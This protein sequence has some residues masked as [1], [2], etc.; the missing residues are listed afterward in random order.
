MP[1]IKN[2][3]AAQR[4][5]EIKE[6]ILRTDKE[7]QSIKGGKLSQLVAFRLGTEEYALKIEEIKEVVLT[8]P[9]THVP[10]VPS[11]IKGVANIRGNLLA[12]FDLEER[13]GIEKTGEGT[14]RYTLVL[15][16][17]KNKIGILVQDVP[18]TIS[19][20]EDD[21]D[22]SNPFLQEAAIDDQAIHSLAK[23]GN[24]LIILLNIQNVLGRDEILNALS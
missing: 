12:I 1:E 13:L 18:N 9:I 4:Q 6:N 2:Q 17:E 16:D 20:S 11:Y 22:D 10:Q 8:P 14:S 23:V 5:Q 24:R 3:I 15:D 19:I 7:E 21:L